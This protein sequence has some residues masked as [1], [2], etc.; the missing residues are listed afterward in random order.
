[1]P[2][3]S[4][5]T[6]TYNQLDNLKK[7]KPFWDRQTL[8]DFEWVLASDGSTDGTDEWA[9]SQGIKIYQKEKNTGFD[10]TGC[11]NQA[12]KLCDG[13]YL[14]FVMGDTYP[15]S[16]FLE[17]IA[18]QI[19]KRTLVNGIRFDIDWETDEVVRPE[20]RTWL[21]PNW[22]WWKSNAFDVPLVK[23]NGSFMPA[24]R[25][26]TLNSLA[27]PAKLWDEM[28][29][30]PEDFDGYGKMDWYIGAWILFNGYRFVS[31]NKAV[32]YHRM[33]DDRADS[34]TANKVFEKYIRQFIVESGNKKV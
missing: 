23:H 7:I 22:P 18:E 33:H 14:V 16:D 21:N 19:D 32:V 27:I 24:W 4:V 3:F 26:A 17:K 12:R 6:L 2:K 25:M 8:N 34:D 20:W 13:E 5:V 28:G 15:K 9:K 29:G 30:I 1:M 10:L 31:A 11:L